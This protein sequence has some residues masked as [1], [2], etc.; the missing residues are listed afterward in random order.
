MSKILR[1]HITRVVRKRGQALSVPE[2]H[3]LRIARDSMRYACP[4][5]GVLGGP[6]HYRAASIIHELTGQIVCIDA[7]C[8]CKR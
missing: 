4:M 6:N 8:V 5:L 1:K 7:D 2:R 3:Q